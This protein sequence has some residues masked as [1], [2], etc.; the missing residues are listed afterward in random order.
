MVALQVAHSVP[1]TLNSSFPPPPHISNFQF[2]SVVL[3]DVMAACVILRC[4]VLRT[5][6]FTIVSLIKKSFS[7]AAS[8]ILRSHKENHFSASFFLQIVGFLMLV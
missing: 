8:F 6:V 4:K 5:N 7:K 2:F 3:C 1:T